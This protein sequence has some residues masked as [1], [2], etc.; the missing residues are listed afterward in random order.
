MW[1]GVAECFS[2]QVPAQ[3]C[4]CAASAHLAPPPPPAGSKRQVTQ[5]PD[6]AAHMAFHHFLPG[7]CFHSF[8]IKVGFV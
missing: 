8:V 3:D 5:P 1:K 6:T 7:T 2:S 4:G